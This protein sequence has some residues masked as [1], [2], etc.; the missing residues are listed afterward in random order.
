MAW[1]THRHRGRPADSA[2]LA[3]A[4]QGGV[5]AGAA[6]PAP[7]AG[8][9]QAPPTAAAGSSSLPVAV[10][11]PVGAIVGTQPNSKRRKASLR[12]DGTRFEIIDDGIREPFVMRGDVPF[13]D[14]EG[15]TKA[16]GFT[17]PSAK[18]DR[19]LG[20]WAAH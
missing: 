18:H 6:P 17:K 3:A 11:V 13:H 15:C 2:A 5:G 9:A 14:V 8:I 4:V 16:D 20:W 1:P 12:P 10:A 7:A 19:A